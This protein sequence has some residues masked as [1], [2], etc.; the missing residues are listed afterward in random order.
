VGWIGIVV[1]GGSPSAHFSPLVADLIAAVDAGGEPAVIAVGMPI[2]LPDAGARRADTLPPKYRMS[3]IRR[4]TDRDAEQGLHRANETGHEGEHRVAKVALRP[5]DD[6]DLDTLFDQMR[7]P[8]SVR[9]AA[10]TAKDPD[11]RQA[12]DAHMA[13]VRTSPDVTLRRVTRD[14]RV[15]GSIASFVIDG[16]TEITYWIDR[17]VWGEGIA[18]RAL[19]AFLDTV[20][21][22]PLHAR[23]ATD[24][25]WSR[26][27]GRSTGSTRA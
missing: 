7:D 17:F 12:F 25:G 3:L 9:M 10:F 5:L 20:P 23:A 26:P 27:G 2:G 24:T 22:R 13:R 6:A 14:G 8:E 15:V 4:P 18:S 1:G 11:D 19:A 16:D 21:T